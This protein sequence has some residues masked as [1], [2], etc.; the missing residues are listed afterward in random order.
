MSLSIVLSPAQRN[1]LLDYYRSHSDPAVRLRCHILLLLGDGHSWSLITTVLFCSSRT[2][3]RW[4]KRFQSG[5]VSAV[6]GQRRGA[7]RR[8]GQYWVMLVVHWFTTLSPRVFGFLRSRWTCALAALL[9]REHHRLDVSQET[10][11]RWLHQAELVWRRP[12]PILKRRDPRRT[13]ILEGLR[14]LLRELPED[15]TA[16]FMDEVDIN[17]NPDIGFMWMRRG[18]QAKIVTPGDNEKN[19]LAGSLNWR[20]GAVLAPVTGPRRNAQLVAEHLRELCR[21]VRRYRVIH[22]IWDSPKIHDCAVVN[23]VLAEHAD[24]LRVHFLPKYSPDCNPIERIWWHLREEITRNHQCKTLEELIDLV[25]DWLGESYFEVE[26]KIYREP[27]K[28]AALA[29]AG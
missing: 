19:Y 22:V 12:R 7:P 21:Q 29:K 18:Q 16:V 27:L 23:K 11:R 15:E 13:A 14:V 10:V 4:Q 3:D 28:T 24:R 6:L 25:I 2:I 26:D 9:L 17:L 8:Y 1:T 20:T 5:G